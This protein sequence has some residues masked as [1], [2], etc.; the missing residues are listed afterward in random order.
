M[1]KKKKAKQS[2]SHSYDSEKTMK[3]LEEH[4]PCP[5]CGLRGL[6]FCPGKKSHG[7][8]AWKKE[9]SDVQ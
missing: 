4:P 1:S 3:W 5:L 6:H 7:S 9:N 2:E 8:D